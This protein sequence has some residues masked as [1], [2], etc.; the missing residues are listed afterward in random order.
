M[1]KNQ[2]EFKSLSKKYNSYANTQ[3]NIFHKIN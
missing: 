3:N 2:N 1:F